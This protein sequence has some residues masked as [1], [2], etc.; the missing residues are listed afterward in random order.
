VN[1][2]TESSSTE[3]LVGRLRDRLADERQ[4]WL[5]YLFGSAA[6]GRL[7]PLSD[8]DVAVLGPDGLNRLRLDADLAGAAAPRRLDLVDLARAPI[9]MRYRIVRD[10][11]VLISRDEALRMDLEVT[12]IDRYL[13]MAPLR[14][15]MSEGLRH[16]LAEDRFGR[17]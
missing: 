17:A 2:G 10:G 4:V 9:A 15:T 6:L 12:T 1:G 13:D 11:I 5:A 3:A 7:R 16:R 14:R 8:V